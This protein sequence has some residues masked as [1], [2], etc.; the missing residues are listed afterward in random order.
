MTCLFRC[1]NARIGRGWN[2]GNG[3]SHCI[4]AC[5]TQGWVG[6]Q[7]QMQLKLQAVPRAAC[8]RGTV[9]RKAPNTIPIHIAHASV[10]D[11]TTC[12]YASLGTCEEVPSGLGVLLPCECY[13]GAVFAVPGDF[14]VALHEMAVEGGGE[15]CDRC[16]LVGFRSRDAGHQGKHQQHC[17]SNLRCNFQQ[18]QQHD[19]ECIYVV[20]QQ[21]VT[22]STSKRSS[23]CRAVRAD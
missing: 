14:R 12:T 21:Q 8:G 13:L 6:R 9:V 22:V 20:A 5:P 15:A 3:P 19:H 4:A 17:S 16:R 1:H 10:A 18:E 2:H 23:S 11:R 7:A